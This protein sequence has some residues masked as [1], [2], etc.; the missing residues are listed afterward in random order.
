MILLSARSNITYQQGLERFWSYK[1][2]YDYYQPEFANLGEVA[3]YNREIY[4][5]NNSDQNALPFAYNEYGYHLRYGMNYVTREMRSN[6][7]QSLDNMHMADD[8]GS[9]PTLGSAWIQSN[10]DISR[11]IA[12]AASTADPI[13]LN[14]MAKGSITRVMP[15]YSVPGLLRL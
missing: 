4:M 10:T 14:M 13:Q 1:T 6:Y 5:Q 9:L 12:V 11:N 15:M 2:R 8:Y 7:A 3:I